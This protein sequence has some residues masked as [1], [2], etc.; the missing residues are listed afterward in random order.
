MRG[1]RGKRKFEGREGQ[2]SISGNAVNA[3]EETIRKKAGEQYMKCR[4]RK[5]MESEEPG[6]ACSCHNE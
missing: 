6:E 5:T 4:S 2:A 1:G 3:A